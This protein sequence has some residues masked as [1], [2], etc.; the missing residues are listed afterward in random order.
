ME[1]YTEDGSGGHGHLQDSREGGTPQGNTVISRRG[2]RDT[3]KGENRAKGSGTVR[4]GL[5][6][7]SMS[8]KHLPQ[9]SQDLI[10]ILRLLEFPNV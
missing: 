5:Y 3:R 1:E 2:K 9:T 10:K 4:W 6:G 8:W 7:A